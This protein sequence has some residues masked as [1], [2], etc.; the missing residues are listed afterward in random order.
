MPDHPIL[1]LAATGGQ[2]R[3]VCTAL[4]ERGAPLRALVRNPNSSGAGPS[5]SVAPRSST[6]SLDDATSL[7][8][9]MTDV[10]AVFAMTTP[11]ESGV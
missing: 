10:A 11:F 7:A 1:V 9:A 4:L 2:G 3:A 6:G 8:A 5:P